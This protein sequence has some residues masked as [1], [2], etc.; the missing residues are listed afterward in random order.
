MKSHQ[1]I[2]QEEKEKIYLYRS[3]VDSSSQLALNQDSWTNPGP[4]SLHKEEPRIPPLVFWDLYLYLISISVHFEL[5][6][7]RALFPTARCDIQ[8][9]T[10]VS[11]DIRTY[12]AGH[13]LHQ[14]LHISFSAS[15]L[16]SV[17]LLAL[18]NNQGRECDCGVE[19]GSTA[20]PSFYKVPGTPWGKFGFLLYR[21]KQGTPG[22]HQFSST[23]KGKW[24]KLCLHW[25]FPLLGVAYTLLFNPYMQRA[26]QLGHNLASSLLLVPQWGPGLLT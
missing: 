9:H 8:G 25:V 5:N 26:H 17:S 18:F 20:S 14:S 11:Q 7:L 6:L 4:G 13:M 1:T 15:L 3:D 12:F 23:V 2:Q 21:A 24:K 19:Q 16:M 10:P 22:P